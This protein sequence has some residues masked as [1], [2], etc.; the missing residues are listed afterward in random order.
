MKADKDYIKD[1]ET[2]RS[3]M[4]R[5]SKFGSLAGWAGIM[6]G[7]Y[8]IAGTFFTYSFLKFNP[9]QIF[10]DYTNSS[11][12]SFMFVIIIAITV[13]VLAIGT[14]ILLTNKR[15]AGNGEKLWSLTTKRML[16]NMALPLV[17]GG[18]LVLILKSNGLLGL[19]APITLI[20]YGFALFNAGRYTY[21]EVKVL[22]VIQVTLGLIGAFFIEYSLL[23]WAIGFGLF[24][25]IF[26]IYLHKKYEK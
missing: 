14:A 15:A 19:I 10:Y 22:G 7:L 8:A 9:N 5:S 4:E 21:D 24:H 13:L 18:L 2:I 20:F 12:N 1:I 26:G 11:G 3:M 25:I 23:C 17:A 6:A 16:G